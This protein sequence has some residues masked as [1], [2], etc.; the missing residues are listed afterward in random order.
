MS[1]SWSAYT[2]LYCEQ[3]FHN[4]NKEVSKDDLIAHDQICGK[5]PLVKRIK[6]LEEA[7]KGALNITKYEWNEAGEHPAS[8]WAKDVK[9]FE[10]ILKGGE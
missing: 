3:T 6:E 8:R 7:V 10:Q 2:C 9:Y 4:A 5:N 1:F